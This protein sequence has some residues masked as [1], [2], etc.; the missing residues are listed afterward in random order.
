MAQVILPVGSIPTSS[1]WT[2]TQGLLLGQASFL[3]LVLLFV[4]YVVFSPSE[5]MDSEGW[6]K[7]RAEKSKVSFLMVV[8]TLQAYNT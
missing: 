6:K 2:F 1:P 7:K 8:S 5:A 4:R 3:V